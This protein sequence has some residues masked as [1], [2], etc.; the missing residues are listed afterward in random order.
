MKA[1]VLTERDLGCSAC[2]WQLAAV[3]ASGTGSDK[4]RGPLNTLQPQ[5]CWDG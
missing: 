2:Q 4:E 3:G 1:A 5:I